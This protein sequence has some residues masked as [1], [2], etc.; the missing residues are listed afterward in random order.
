MNY[1]NHN[2]LLLPVERLGSGTLY[3][4]AA[5][6]QRLMNVA[7]WHQDHAEKATNVRDM[8]RHADMADRLFIASHRAK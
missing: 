6:S 7:I 2:G 4:P 8:A 3:V 5:D 1:I